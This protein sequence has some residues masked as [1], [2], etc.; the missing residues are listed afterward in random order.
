M[1]GHMPGVIMPWPQVASRGDGSTI[2]ST[3]QMT[4]A[5]YSHL[6]DP[7]PE[8][9]D[10]VPDGVGRPLGHREVDHQLLGA[11]LPLRVPVIRSH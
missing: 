10:A 3:R 7:G 4:A 1:R 6:D 2:A 11:L 5:I 8:H 9:G